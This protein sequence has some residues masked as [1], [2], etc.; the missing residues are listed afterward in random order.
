[1]GLIV[2][3]GRMVALLGAVLALALLRSNLV[4]TALTLLRGWRPHR[5]LRVHDVLSAG[6]DSMSDE[7]Q[8]TVHA[9]QLF[10]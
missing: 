7:L 2:P 5:R 4:A 8:P 1:V 9:P 3:M 6:I 10:A